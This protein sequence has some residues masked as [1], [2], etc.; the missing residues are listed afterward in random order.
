MRHYLPKRGVIL[1]KAAALNLL[2]FWTL[3]K[4]PCQDVIW[5]FVEQQVRDK[6]WI[7]S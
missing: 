3:C 4:L 7:W 5:G 6:A 1:V 2:W